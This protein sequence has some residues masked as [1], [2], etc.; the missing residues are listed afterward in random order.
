VLG[1]LALPVSLHAAGVAFG[2]RAPVALAAAAGAAFFLLALLPFFRPPRAVASLVALELLLVG[3]GAWAVLAQLHGNSDPALIAILGVSFGLCG[4]LYWDCFPQATLGV[5]T[6]TA[7][8][9]AW[10]GVFPAAY[11]L[12][13]WLPQLQLN[14]ELWNVPKFVVAFG[15]I[16]ALCENQSRVIEEGRAREHAENALLER[17]S[18]LTSQ[19][20]AGKDPLA[21]AGEVAEAITAAAGFAGAAILLADVQ[22]TLRLAGSSGY[23]PAELEALGRATDWSFLGA[24]RRTPAVSPAFGRNSFR[25][26]PGASA[27]EAAPASGR[28][29][30]EELVIPLESSRGSRLGYILLSPSQGS[31]LAASTLAKLEM[32]A[33]DL[34]VSLENAR[35]HDHLVRSEK[36]AALGQLVAG[37]A[38][39]LNN[40]LTGVMGY[41]ELLG[42]E[43]KTESARTRLEKLR[44]QARRMKRIVHGLLRFARQSNA[45]TSAAALEPALREVLE[46]REHH[47]GMRKIEWPVE[48]EPRLPAVAI[49]EDELKQIFLNLLNNAVDALEESR[50]RIIRIEAKHGAECVIVRFEDTGPGFADPN[51]AFD[52][53][54]TTK[55][56]GKG[57]GLGLSICYGIVR[58]YGG[59]I[60]LANNEPYGARVTIELP[61][62]REAACLLGA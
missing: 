15:M 7:G 16:L 22:G 44:Q 9:L 13:R 11:A 8:F 1:L 54:Y 55:P 4:V 32:L 58:K 27:F 18:R 24:I 47:L 21:L 3:A 33:A 52:P 37:V 45:E 25:V 17:L 41:A 5:L 62:A 43:V 31:A 35:L 46:L 59:Q 56:V 19:L 10:G 57:T 60:N 30:G 20:L 29:V 26:R 50:E 34:A 39:E 42:D 48:I 14:P 51:R 2:W 49:G 40:P 61:R 6:V 53:F 38:H 36:L 12:Q 23:A 28:E